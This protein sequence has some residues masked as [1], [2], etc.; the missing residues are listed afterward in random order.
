MQKRVLYFVYALRRGVKYCKWLALVLMAW[1]FMFDTCVESTNTKLLYITKVLECFLIAAIL[2]VVKV[3]LVKV[4]GLSFPRV[5]LLCVYSVQYA[6]T[7]VFF[8]SFR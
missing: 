4:L 6:L 2:L 5:N 7:F 1:N 8:V 3:F